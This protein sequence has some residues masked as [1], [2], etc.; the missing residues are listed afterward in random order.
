MQRFYC[1]QEN[2]CQCRCH[3]ISLDVIYTLPRVDWE[4][5]SRAEERACHCIAKFEVYFGVVVVGMWD[6]DWA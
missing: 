6:K 2:R 1:G 3:R 5:N 4:E